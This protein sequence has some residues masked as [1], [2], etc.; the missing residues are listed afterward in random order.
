[1]HGQSPRCCLANALRSVGY[2]LCAVHKALVA[3]RMLLCADESGLPRTV[4]IPRQK[5]GQLTTQLYIVG[6]EGYV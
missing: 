2:T 3:L 4:A 5:H 1:M 6:R